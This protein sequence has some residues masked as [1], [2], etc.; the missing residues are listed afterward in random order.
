MVHCSKIT[1]LIVAKDRGG[2]SSLGFFVLKLGQ[3]KR[4][5]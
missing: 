5:L 4:F 3:E 2:F 1:G